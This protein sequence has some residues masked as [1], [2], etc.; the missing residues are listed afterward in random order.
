MHLCVDPIP[1]FPEW[2]HSFYLRMLLDRLVK[3]AFALERRFD[4]YRNASLFLAT[5]VIVTLFSLDLRRTPDTADS[6]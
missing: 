2:S 5:F 1:S 4:E 6:M 3:S